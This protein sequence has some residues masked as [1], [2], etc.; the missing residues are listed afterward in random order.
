MLNVTQAAGTYLND[1][2]ESRHAPADTAVR[3]LVQPKGLATAIDQEHAGDTSI[4]HEGRKVLLLDE[5]AA[6]ALSERTLDVDPDG[7]R[8]ICLT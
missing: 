8:L 5:K 3:I 4:E 7:P 2:L 1:L 6:D